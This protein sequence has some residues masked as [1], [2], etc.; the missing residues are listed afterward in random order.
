MEKSEP[1]LAWKSIVKD[2]NLLQTGGMKSMD[3]LRAKY[4]NMKAMKRRKILENGNKNME[5]RTCKIN[6]SLES[7]EIYSSSTRKFGSTDK[8]ISGIVNPFDFDNLDTKTDI[9]E[10]LEENSLKGTFSAD[11]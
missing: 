2:Y 4:K 7:T 11:T 5:L 3:S 10:I 8:R 1:S 6:S 9:N